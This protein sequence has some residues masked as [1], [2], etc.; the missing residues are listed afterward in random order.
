[1]FEYRIEPVARKRS[2]LELAVA[3]ILS[4]QSTDKRVNLTTPALFA[5]YR[6][7]KDYAEPAAVEATLAEIR[8]P[9]GARGRARPVH[10][11]SAAD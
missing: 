4:A 3:T 7:A 1:M 11:T 2:P 6:T 10:E 5:R 8:G 9:A